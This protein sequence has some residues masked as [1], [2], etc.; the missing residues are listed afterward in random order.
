MESIFKMCGKC[1][2]LSG[3]TVDSLWQEKSLS[4]LLPDLSVEAEVGKLP[5]LRALAGA[6]L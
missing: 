4:L 6:M 2:E 3:S 1:T 5:H